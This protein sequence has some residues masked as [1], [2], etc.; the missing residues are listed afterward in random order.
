MQ[1]G[2][3]AAWPCGRL[4]LSAIMALTV[5]LAQNAP[6]EGQSWIEGRAHGSARPSA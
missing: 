1:S 3:R 4:G 2:G 6:L 5:V